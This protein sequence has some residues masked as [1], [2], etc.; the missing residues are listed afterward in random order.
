VT[1]TANPDVHA[2]PPTTREA[3]L[4]FGLLL[5]SLVVVVGLAKMLA[6]NRARG[7]GS[8]CA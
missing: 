5:V 6:C 2:E 3:W 8:Q 4:S 7:R 1:D